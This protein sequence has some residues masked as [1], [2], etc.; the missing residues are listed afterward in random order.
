MEQKFEEK[1]L[2]DVSIKSILAKGRVK[3]GEWDRSVNGTLHHKSYKIKDKGDSFL[4]PS[5]IY[6]KKLFYYSDF[7]SDI[8]QVKIIILSLLG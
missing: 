7:L 3:S 1:Y 5:K 6:N 2:G 8:F 4:G